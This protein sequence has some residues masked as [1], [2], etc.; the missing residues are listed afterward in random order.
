MRSR[1]GR[2]QLGIGL[3]MG[4]PVIGMLVGALIGPALA[5]AKEA[6]LV[7]PPCVAVVPIELPLGTM[8]GAVH[9]PFHG[10]LDATGNGFDYRPEER[11]WQARGDLVMIELIQ[12]STGQSEELR[13]RIAP[14]TTGWDGM[15]VSSGDLT[16]A[17]PSWV[18]WQ[19]DA[20]HLIDT[21]PGA[22]ADVAYV[23]RASDS[24]S[25]P[26]IH[27]ELSGETSSKGSE[28][29]A[30]A[31]VEVRDIPGL[32]LLKPNAFH[33]YRVHQGG[34]T[35]VELTAEWEAGTWYVRPINDQQITPAERYPLRHGRNRLQLHRWTNQGFSG[36]LLYI[37]GDLAA[38]IPA[39]AH[40]DLIPET[41]EIA[42]RHV[43][44]PGDLEL[45][46]E[47][48]TARRSANVIETTERILLDGFTTGERPSWTM[49]GNPA[50]QSLSPQGLPGP[51][52]RL[53]I[54]LDGL[55]GLQSSYLEQD[56]ALPPGGVADPDGYGVRFWVDPTAVAMPPGSKLALVAA[57]PETGLCGAL[58][59]RL[60]TTDSGLALAAT[61]RRDDGT[62]AEISMP[63]PNMPH[64]VE[65]RLRNG[66]LPDVH[67]GWFEL[68][69][70]G[71]LAGRAAGLANHGM[72][73]A[74]LRFGALV[75][76]EGSG[77]VLGLD[78]LEVWRFD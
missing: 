20:P 9:G 61:A 19:L 10:T 76:P 47:G 42:I 48:L 6:T 2:I 65:V 73:L 11:F 1:N 41:H 71:E 74:R 44:G 16:G 37:D 77:G 57:C 40:D 59:V 5:T 60:D 51:G 67:N 13:V 29:S 62:V 14:G 43:L 69:V 23:F 63:I 70:D 55:A 33:F 15:V 28:S 18:P 30:E 38:S 17:P 36:A 75:D 68:R 78:D 49:I 58:R 53:D 7:V 35:V 52:Q 4:M 45:V 25:E 34:D 50:P 39:A 31:D 12:P 72:Q 22:L 24:A 27:A 64:H 54:D 26:M 56:F 32:S 21:E 3:G 46:I 8:A 66:W